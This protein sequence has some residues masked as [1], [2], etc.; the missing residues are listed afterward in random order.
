MQESIYKFMKPGLVHFMAYPQTMA[1]EGP[2]LETLSETAADDFFTAIEIPRYKDPE[3]RKKARALLE[4]A[5]LT[6]A[7]AAQPAVLMQGLNPNSLDEAERNKAVEVLKGEIDI[8]CEMGAVGLAV[9]SGKDP[10]EDKR[11]EAK[12]ALSSSI[13]QLCAYAK[14]KGDLKII[15]ETFDRTIDKKALIGPSK[16]AAEIAERVGEENFGLMLDLSH[17]PLQDETP[18]EALKNAAAHLVHAHLGNCVMQDEAHP[19]YGDQH[20]G[21]GIPGGENSVAEVREFLRVL[22]DIGFLGE[23]LPIVSFEVKPMEGETSA[24]LIAN[25]KRTLKV[26]WASL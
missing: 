8:A 26:A 7:Y 20:P 4:S 19:A 13:K 17:L 6:I 12:E 24:A 9:L 10:G 16:E 15:L 21:F 3:V 14:S 1:G 2:I 23:S 5:G 11:T 18:E 25:A 22:L